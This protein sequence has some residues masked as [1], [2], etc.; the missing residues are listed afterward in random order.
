MTIQIH[1]WSA[2]L[3]PAIFWEETPLLES[4]I[5]LPEITQNTHTNASNSPHGYEPPRTQ[6]L[7]FTLIEVRSGCIDSTGES[8]RDAWC[9]SAP[10]F[11]C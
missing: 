4:Q 7:E 6:S 2:V 1:H 3:I 5:P 10:G 11:I 8:T 9:Q